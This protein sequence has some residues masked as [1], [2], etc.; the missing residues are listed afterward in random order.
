MLKQTMQTSYQEIFYF[1]LKFD[2]L[3]D[4]LMNARGVWSIGKRD[5]NFQRN[6]Q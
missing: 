4:P 2:L 5:L 1:N 6:K 3:V